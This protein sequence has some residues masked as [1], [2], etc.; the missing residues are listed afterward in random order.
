MLHIE[1]LSS[2]KG[3]FKFFSCSVLPA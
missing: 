3:K 2:G 1:V